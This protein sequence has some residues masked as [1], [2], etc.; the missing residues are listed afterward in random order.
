MS[1]EVSRFFGKQTSQTL[2]LRGK[3]RGGEGRLA[4]KQDKDRTKLLVLCSIREVKRMHVFTQCFVSLCAHSVSPCVYLCVCVCV[5]VCMCVP[6]QVGVCLCASTFL[7]ART[8]RTRKARQIHKGYVMSP[9]AGIHR[10]QV[11]RINI[12]YTY[13]YSRKL[14]ICLYVL[15]IT[16]FFSLQTACT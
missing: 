12:N 14:A 5:Y 11:S 1:T 9:N 10:R 3:V 6:E 2:W 8:C 7:Y 13:C 4:E 16:W 15:L